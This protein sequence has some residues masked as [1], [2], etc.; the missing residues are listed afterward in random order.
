MW[1][2]KGG[3]VVEDKADEMNRNM[4]M[5]RLKYRIG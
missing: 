4:R 3:E 1:E 2:R 5:Y